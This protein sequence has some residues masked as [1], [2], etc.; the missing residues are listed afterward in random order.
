[1]KPKWRKVAQLAWNPAFT[2]DQVAEV[3]PRALLDECNAEFVRRVDRALNPTVQTKLFEESPQEVA[4]RLHQLRST[5][6][7]SQFAENLIEAAIYAVY[8][9]SRDASVMEVAL[10]SALHATTESA[11][12]GIE[13]HGLRKQGRATAESLRDRLI[14]AD[15]LLDYS[16]IGEQL[17]VGPQRKREAVHQKHT[18]LDEGVSL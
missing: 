3:V 14:A 17:M 16:K 2:P 6:P 5:A 13:E 1:M 15:G 9:P 10:P 12:R 18:G 11:I 7:G 8:H 4:A